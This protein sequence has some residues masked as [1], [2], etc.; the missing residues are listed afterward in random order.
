ME[1]QLLESY[2]TPI[3]NLRI[4]QTSKTLQGQGMETTAGWKNMESTTTMEAVV[5]AA[6]PLL[7]ML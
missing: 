5:E 6:E 4:I 7:A 2:I 3:K 1:H